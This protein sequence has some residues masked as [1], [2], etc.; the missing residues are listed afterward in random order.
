LHQLLAVE[1]LALSAVM[2]LVSG[3]YPA[4]E[5]TQ[6]ESQRQRVRFA[7]RLAAY[8]HWVRLGDNPLETHD[9]N[10]YFP[11]EHLRLYSLCDNQSNERM[12]LS[13]TI[14]AGP[15]QRRHSQFRVPQDSW[16]YFTASDSKPPQTWGPV[17]RIYIPRNRVDRLY[18]QVLGSL[19]IAS[20]DPQ[21][22]GG[23]I[24]PRLQLAW[25]PR[26]IASRLTQ[27]KTPPATVFL[28]LWAISLRRSGYRWP[29]W[30]P[31]LSNSTLLL[32]TVAQQLY[33][34]LHNKTNINNTSQKT[35]S[36]SN[37]RQTWPLL[38]KY[39]VNTFPKLHFRQ[40]KDIAR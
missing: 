20:Y 15:R 8:R 25:G 40:E 35:S 1:I 38:G 9:P 27:K 30:R 12:G 6:P 17:P 22:Y 21:G 16:P 32:T 10:L 13:F 2:S 31:L 36:P 28:L 5:L 26:Y 19:F 39:S 18:P 37:I 24:R 33:Y 29:V 34:T 4:T 14:A 11:T 23:S 3:E 7:L